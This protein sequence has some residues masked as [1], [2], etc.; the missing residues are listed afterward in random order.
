MVKKMT[1]EHREAN[2]RARDQNKA[3][4]AYLSA[5]EETRPRRGRRLTKESIQKKLDDIEEAFDAATPLKRVQLIQKR[6]DLEQAL[7]SMGE[8]VPIEELEA[9]FV[10]MAGAYSKRKNI[11]YQAW[12][13][14][15]VPAAVLKKADI[16]YNRASG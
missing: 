8:T 1:A 13:E 16:S 14:M 2:Q 15:G 6:I 7:E 9:Q 11:S 10:E 4:G 5:L 12:R 3:V